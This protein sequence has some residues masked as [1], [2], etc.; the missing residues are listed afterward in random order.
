MKIL[1]VEDEPVS[2][3]LLL[4]YLK[5]YGECD[6]VSDGHEALDAFTRAL[7]EKHPYT[8]VCLDI[9]LPAMNGQQVLGLIRQKEEQLGID[10]NS[11]QAAKIFMTTGYKDSENY[12]TAFSETC[13]AYLIKPVKQRQLIRKMK[14]LNLI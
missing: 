5:K 7:E 2:R 6:T 8:L 9:D 13:D 12:M 10:I 1:I 14:E 4:N 3:T 11:P